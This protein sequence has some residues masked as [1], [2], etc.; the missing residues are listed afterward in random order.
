MSALPHFVENLLSCL[1]LPLPIL[2]R[3]NL[4]I[5][6]DA[7]TLYAST[8]PLPGKRAPSAV[9]EKSPLLAALEENAAAPIPSEMRFFAPS[10]RARERVKNAIRQACG[11]A[12]LAQ[13]IGADADIVLI[14]QRVYP[15]VSGA[16]HVKFH[17]SF[18]SATG[19]Q[20]QKKKKKKKK[21]KKGGS[22]WG[23]GFQRRVTTRFCIGSLLVQVF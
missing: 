2:L 14:R 16:F 1:L 15:F 19:R 5:S 22:G 8:T 17:F 13:R 12:A 23:L 18:A 3:T 6:Q 20:I 10:K 7:T 21:K 11:N 4:A 9:A